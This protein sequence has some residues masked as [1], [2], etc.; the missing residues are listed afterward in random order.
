MLMSCTSL[1]SRIRRGEQIKVLGGLALATALMGLP[2]KA[3][4]D[5]L[6]PRER[7][8]F[9]ELCTGWAQGVTNWAAPFLGEK[10]EAA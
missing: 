9:S 8:S 7:C 2:L 4:R 6:A 1:A 10:A 5:H 3:E